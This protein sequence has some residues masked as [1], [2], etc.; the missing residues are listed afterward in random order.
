M[1]C[2]DVCPANWDHM[3]WVVGGAVFSEER[4]QMM[5]EVGSIQELHREIVEEFKEIYKFHESPLHRNL[6][7]LVNKSRN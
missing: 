7:V 1:I 3:D 4:A 5:L 6:G 2:W